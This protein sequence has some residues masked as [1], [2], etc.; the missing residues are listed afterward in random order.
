MTQQLADLLRDLQHA[1]DLTTAD[2][3]T[4]LSD[5]D[6]DGLRDLKQ[7]WPNLSAERRLT[8]LTQLRR[9]GDDRI[10]LTFEKVSR[11]ALTDPAPEVRRQAIGNLWECEDPA[12]VVPLSEALS[13]DTDPS[14]REAAASALGQF[15]FLG[16]V[17][18]VPEGQRRVAEERLLHAACHDSESAVRLAGLEALGFSSRPEVPAL[19]EAAYRTG[20]ERQVH[21]ALVA[22]G[23]SANATWGPAV[24][25]ELASPAPLLRLVAARAAGELD[26]RAA[27]PTLVE[28]LEDVSEDVRRASIWS[29][30]ELGGQQAE[31]ALQSLLRRKPPQDE[32]ALLEE[33]LENL[34]FVDGTRDF[35]MLDFDDDVDDEH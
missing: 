31:R 1:P 5:L 15:V 12:L 2:R 6:A 27:V 19:I 33:A 32:V 4:L 3:L 11:F 35:L 23:R 26:L 14:V 13:A 30:G 34:A 16:E 28:L 17:Q 24:T 22:M 18:R 20:E 10:E 7:A 25:A 8:L 9:L 21:S 29:L